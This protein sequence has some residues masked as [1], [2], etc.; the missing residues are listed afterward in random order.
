MNIVDYNKSAWDSYVDRKDRWTV[1]VGAD[2]INKAKDGE[3]SVILTPTLPVPLNWFAESFKDLKILG[4][5]CG[6]GQQGPILASLGAEVT[7]FDNSPKQLSQDA[8]LSSEFN[9][10]IKTVEG[11]MRDLSIFADESFDLI[12]NPCSI[13]FV[14]DIQPIWNECNR[15][16]KK[17]GILLTGLTNPLIFQID[18]E[19]LQLKYTAPYSDQRSLS[20]EDLNKFV[21]NND[22]LMFAHS[23]TEQ[24]AGQ[25]K[26]GF[27]LTDMYEDNWGGE[28]VFDPY[29]SGFM[30][31]RAVKK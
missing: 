25:M 12:F 19:M 9:L 11:D 5:A 23:W 15:V 14:D 6:G 21:S 4:L 28:H 27:I 30:A 26:A 3:W 16:L 18:E 2:E 20:P 8:T 22:P 7:I 1:P 10:N 17:G 13:G 29:F 31:T 24:I